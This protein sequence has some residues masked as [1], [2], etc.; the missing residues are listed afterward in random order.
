MVDFDNDF[1]IVC[2][3]GKKEGEAEEAEEAEAAGESKTTSTS[4]IKIFKKVQKIALTF[5]RNGKM[6]TN[7]SI[8]I[9]IYNII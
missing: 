9:Y 6:L 1:R 4:V 5:A 2:K 7:L 3:N 8:Y